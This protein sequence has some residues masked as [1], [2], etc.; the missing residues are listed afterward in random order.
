MTDFMT[1]LF[2]ESLKVFLDSTPMLGADMGV[3][4]D[5]RLC[6]PGFNLVLSYRSMISK[7]II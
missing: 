7:L 5:R 1:G 3:R 4:A 6:E 2:M